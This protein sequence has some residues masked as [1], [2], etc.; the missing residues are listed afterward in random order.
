MMDR[1]PLRP[2]LDA[3]ERV[4][5]RKT[6]ARKLMPEDRQTVALEAIAA[7]LALIQGELQVLRESRATAAEELRRGSSVHG[8]PEQHGPAEQTTKLS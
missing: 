2:I 3:R 6:L 4:E 5:N 7:E 8:R 1:D